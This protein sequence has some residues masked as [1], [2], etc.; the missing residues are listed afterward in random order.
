[1][2]YWHLTLNKVMTGVHPNS[3][4]ISPDPETIPFIS[5]LAPH[6][7]MLRAY[8]WIYLEIT[9]GWAQGITCTTGD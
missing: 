5:V 4:A 6:L 7:M 1:M 9:P 8:S 3:S 2:W